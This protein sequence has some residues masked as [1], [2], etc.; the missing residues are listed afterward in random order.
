M[1]TKTIPDYI[2][3]QGMSD[4][5]LGRFFSKINYTDTCWLWK[6]YVMSN[7]YGSVAKGSSR[8]KE[9]R[10]IL[11]HRASWIVH[12]GPIPEGM[13]VCHEC[14]IGRCVNPAHLW[15]G[16]HQ[17][18]MDDMMRK[19]REAHNIGMFSGERSYK[20]KLTWDQVI[21]IRRDYIPYKMSAPMLAKRYGVVQ[22][23]ISSIIHYKT[24]KQY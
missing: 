13:F 10:T 21:E 7:G 22:S 18:N 11:A 5:F 17:Q 20:A 4:T 16:N 3:S 8:R 14:D 24:W 6:G 19:G 23:V 1:Q 15:L 2:T 12:F 9:S